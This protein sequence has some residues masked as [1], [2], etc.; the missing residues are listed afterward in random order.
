MKLLP[1]GE[2]ALL[3]EFDDLAQTLAAYRGLVADRIDGVV[4]LVPAARTVLIRFDPSA[5]SP[6]AAER[7]IRG[8]SA[9]DTSPTDAPLVRIPVRYEG[10]DLADT[11]GLLGIPVAE[12]IDRH[13]RTE[14][15]CAF[16]GFAP[17]FGYLVSEAGLEVPRLATS[18]PSV[19]PGSVG[20]AGEFSGVYP[21]SSPGGWRLIGT[22]DAPMW[23]V[24]RLSPSLLAPGTRVRFD[25]I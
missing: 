3:A 10:P 5:L 21:R 13:S 16:V 1:F 9:L 11:A 8:S 25:V 24:L 19:P 7:W 12:L 6:R 17:G 22:T 15:T 14:W 4:A 2:A 20:L 18:R 23:D